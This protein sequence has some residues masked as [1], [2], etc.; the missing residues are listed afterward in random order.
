MKKLLLVFLILFAFLLIVG[1]V[2]GS[3][4]IEGIPDY[5]GKIYGFWSGLLHGWIAPF[6]FVISLFSDHVHFYEVHNNGG[7]YN[8]GFLL[9]IGAFAGGLMGIIRGTNR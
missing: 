9:A 4:R 1:C 6:T 3:N 5:E 8:L 7:W 2:P